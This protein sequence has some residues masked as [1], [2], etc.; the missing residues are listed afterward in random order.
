MPLLNV[1]WA[2]CRLY[3]WSRTQ[4]ASTWQISS[5]P[6]DFLC[7]FNEPELYTIKWRL[8]MIPSMVWFLNVTFHHWTGNRAGFTVQGPR[9]GWRFFADLDQ[10]TGGAQEGSFHIGF[11]MLDAWMSLRVWQWPNV[12]QQTNPHQVHEENLCMRV[13]FRLD[14]CWHGDM[15]MVNLDTARPCRS[16]LRH[17][18]LFW[19][20]GASP[21]ESAHTF[22][23]FAFNRKVG[24]CTPQPTDFGHST[25]LVLWIVC[26]SLAITYVWLN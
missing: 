8:E 4:L 22:I 7:F 3:C 19:Q 17:S 10:W 5:P 1:H 15:V 26:P 18:R 12:K 25:S 14:E 20:D 21:Q 6:G 2:R 11:D 23:I 13:S 9:Q 16:S 24:W